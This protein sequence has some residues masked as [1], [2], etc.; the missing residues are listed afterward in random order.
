MAFIATL[1]FALL[2]FTT[3]ADLIT[4][5]VW[6][7]HGIQT[8]ILGA[9]SYL[10]F[11]VVNVTLRQKNEQEEADRR[12]TEMVQIDRLKSDFLSMAQ[13][14]LR[15][16]L[17]GVKWA[18]E[19][20]KA[21]T[22]LPLESQ[23]LIEASLA[24][25]QDSLGIINQMLKTV[26]ND[27]TPTLTR[28]GTDLVGLVQAIIAELNFLIIKKGVKINFI[29]PDSLLVNADRNNIKAALANIID[30]AI[31]YSPK[32]K[33]DVSIVDAPTKA[34]LIVK[35]TGIGIPA[36]DLPYIFDRMHRAKN[37]VLLEPDESGVG[38]SI[39]KKI[40]ELHGG[41]IS[42]ESTINKGTVITVVLPKS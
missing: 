15:T 26:E 19:M 2:I 30:N 32:G 25:V 4:T 14:Q 27:G 20:L 21:D 40:I 28:E 9:L 7:R 11:S 31:K 41:T 37:A 3:P 35:D 24:R 12:I 29:C 1:G 16:P 22:T 17:S 6:V 34:T 10:V 42:L 8:I 23:S 5:D 39:S 13:H 36:D 38:L 33:V 18:L